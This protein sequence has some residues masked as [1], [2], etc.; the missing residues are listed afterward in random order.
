MDTVKIKINDREVEVEK[1]TLLLD[2]AKKVGITIPTLCYHPDLQIKANC[3]ICA[4]EI[5]GYRT[6]RL[7]ALRSLQRACRYTRVP[8][9]CARRVN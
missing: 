8:K 3:R 9:K 4:I 1:G 2:A 7:P 6:C 5:D